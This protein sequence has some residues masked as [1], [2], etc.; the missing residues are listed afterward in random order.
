MPVGY[1]SV[2]FFVKVA[3]LYLTWVYIMFVLGW[4]HLQ[5]FCYI[6]GFCPVIGGY[7]SMSGDRG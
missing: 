4:T 2:R 7:L 1:K 6:V 3:N 5:D